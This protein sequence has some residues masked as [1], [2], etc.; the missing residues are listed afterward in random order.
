[1][2]AL[3]ST[4]ARD[5]DT[6]RAETGFTLHIDF[7]AP[8]LNRAQ[9]IA[10]EIAEGLGRLRRDIDMCS[11]RVSSPD[12]PDKPAP[13]FCGATGPDGERCIDE[14][15]HGGYHDE[16]GVDSYV[17]SDHDRPEIWVR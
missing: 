2:K 9:M 1:V 4:P 5:G 6:A 11:A 3:K 12:E 14:P 8:D 15:D 13:V 17:W 7:S 10:R 16:G